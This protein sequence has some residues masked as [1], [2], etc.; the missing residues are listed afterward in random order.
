MV[1]MSLF[2]SRVFSG[3]IATMMLWAFGIFG[4]YFFTSLYLQD[5]LGFSPTTAGLAF[6][7]MA[8]CMAVFAGAGG[9]IAARVGAHRTVAFGLV[10]VAAGV[11]LV[12]L[13]G[14]GATFAGLMPGFLLIGVG[15]G[16][17]VPLTDALL[18]TMPPQRAGI[19]SAVLNA[20]RE[21]SGLLGITVIGAVLRSR[22]G[23]A[24]QHGATPAGAFL[25]GYQGGL[26]VTVALV[27]A[28]AVVSFVALR[29]LTRQAAPAPVSA[30]RE[31]TPETNRGL[32]GLTSVSK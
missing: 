20:S 19:A 2:R 5:V 3:G 17:N 31:R 1:A 12:S 16:L 26:L 30:D 28:G 10:L 21:V 15:S 27:A 11:Y 8:L 7:P 25:D 9:P 22:Q 4:I 24:L 13:L 23:V 32:A 29:G 14:Q 6:V 18:R